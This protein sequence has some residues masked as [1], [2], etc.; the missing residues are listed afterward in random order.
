MYRQIKKIKKNTKK[1]LILFRLLVYYHF[2][3]PVQDQCFL[4]QMRDKRGRE[5]LPHDQDENMDD[6]EVELLEDSVQSR[7]NN[8]EVYIYQQYHTIFL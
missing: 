7:M 8:D 5:R 2:Y 1:P 4:M 6:Q 3:N